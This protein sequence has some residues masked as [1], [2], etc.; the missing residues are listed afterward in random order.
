MPETRTFNNP[1]HISHGSDWIQIYQSEN[2]HD[3][4]GEFNESDWDIEVT[5][6][7]KAKKPIVVEA[8][9]RHR[10]WPVWHD[11]GEP[12]FFV[13]KA[14]IEDQAWIGYADKNREDMLTSVER[15]YFDD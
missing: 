10:N 3:P 4:C 6:T 12:I 2:Q 9:V 14:I 7:R 11:S 13:V 1:W 8:V 5:F 15:L